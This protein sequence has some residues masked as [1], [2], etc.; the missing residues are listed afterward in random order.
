MSSFEISFETLKRRVELSL[1]SRS[2]LSPDDENQFTR[3][4]LRSRRYLIFS[5]FERSCLNRGQRRSDS[6]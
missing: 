1:S 3:V 2:V 4:S 5:F 6:L